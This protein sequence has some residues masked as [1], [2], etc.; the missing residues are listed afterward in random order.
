MSGLA[1]D[2]L[3]DKQMLTEV[4]RILHSQTLHNSEILKRLLKFLAEKSAYGEANQL[5]EYTIAVDALQKPPS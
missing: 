2:P 5:K 3:A 1:T 4:E